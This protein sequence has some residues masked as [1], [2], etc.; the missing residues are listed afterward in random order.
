MYI[1]IFLMLLLTC[2]L[3]NGI[4]PKHVVEGCFL[5]VRFCFS[6][7]EPDVSPSAALGYP[8]PSSLSPLNILKVIHSCKRV[9]FR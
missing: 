1:F 5:T 2:S 6:D 4:F 8:K 7:F 9:T 3:T